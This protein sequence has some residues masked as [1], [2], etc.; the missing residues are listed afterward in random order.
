MGDL[1]QRD[2]NECADR[3]REGGAARGSSWLPRS[4]TAPAPTF[5]HPPEARSLTCRD[6]C[7]HSACLRRRDRR[8]DSRLLCLRRMRFISRSSVMPCG[9][10][11]TW[12]GGG[13][14]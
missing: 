14:C 2:L 8:A 3:E 4:C 10:G 12:V 13:G 1:R 7:S 6:S 11:R 9:V 5:A